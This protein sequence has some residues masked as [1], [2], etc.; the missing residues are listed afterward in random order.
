MSVYACSDIHGQSQLFTQIL[1][2]LNPTDT[3]Y[4]LGDAIDRG[5]DGWDICKVIIDDPRFIYL[6]GNH[7][8]MMLKAIGDIGPNHN[9]DDDIIGVNYNYSLWFHNGGSTTYNALKKDTKYFYYI[10]HL[11]SLPTLIYYYNSKGHHIYLTHAGF[12]LDRI[13]DITEEDLLWNRTHYYIDTWGGYVNE[14]M[15]HGHT[16]NPYLVSEL[17][18]VLDWLI[19]PI[20]EEKKHKYEIGHSFW[21]C[22]NHKCC[23]DCGAHFTNSIVLLNLDTFEE[24]T[25]NG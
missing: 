6:K 21:Y 5:P 25:F 7:E 20:P 12:N 18:E 10:Q 9:F 2:F 1:D 19:P 4:F 17:N 11:R 16:P 13:R 8:D 14:Y 23:I 22:E 24:V 15:I 3:V